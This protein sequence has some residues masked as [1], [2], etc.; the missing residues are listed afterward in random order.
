MNTNRDIYELIRDALH[1][2]TK[3]QSHVK[4]FTLSGNGH[5]ERVSLDKSMAGILRKC[6]IPRIFKSGYGANYFY[7]KRVFVDAQS[8]LLVRLGYIPFDISP[9][10]VVFLT[11]NSNDSTSTSVPV[12]AGSP[13]KRPLTKNDALANDYETPKRRVLITVEN[14][15][16]GTLGY[17]LGHSIRKALNIM[18]VRAGMTVIHYSPN[19]VFQAQTS[20]SEQQFMSKLQDSF[21]DME[22][23]GRV[24]IRD[25]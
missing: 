18:S 23:P 6:D 12:L 4:D 15:P 22:L 3:R 1:N 14:W 8:D 13:H 11:I 24:T 9:R 5:E 19:R 7:P 2:A 10:G 16:D 25:A 21:K 20:V 17:R